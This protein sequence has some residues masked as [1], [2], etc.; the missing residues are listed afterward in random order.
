MGI[1]N[2]LTTTYHRL[3]GSKYNKAVKRKQFNLTMN[4]DIIEAVRFIAAML[5]VPLYVACEHLLQVGSYHLLEDF[6]DPESRESLK[7]HLVNV[8][9]LGRALDENGLLH[10]A[11]Y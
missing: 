6:N 9:L 1:I 8:H 5:E 4:E 7:E 11:K 3:I 10:G 2:R